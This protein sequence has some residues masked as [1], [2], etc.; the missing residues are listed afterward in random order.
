VKVYLWR[1]LEHYRRED[2]YQS[3]DTHSVTLRAAANC[4]SFPRRYE[5]RIQNVNPWFA[6]NRTPLIRECNSA[7]GIGGRGRMQ[8]C[9]LLAVQV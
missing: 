1:G 7:R 2:C 6:S 5:L 4:T 8:S 3:D 9:V